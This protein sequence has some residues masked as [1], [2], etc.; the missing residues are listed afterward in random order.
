LL[1]TK[2]KKTEK[3][4]KEYKQ[5]A[6]D[7]SLQVQN[8]VKKQLQNASRKTY[9][10]NPVASLIQSSASSSND[11][12]RVISEN[13]VEFDDVDELQ[14]KNAN[15][16]QVVRRLT[17]ERETREKDPASSDELKEAL[18]QIAKLRERRQRQEVMVQSII[19]QRD[20]Y[21]LMSQQ[22]QQSGDNGNN[23]NNNVN[24]GNE[25]PLNNP[26]VST[27]VA[28]QS[29]VA[30]SSSPSSSSSSSIVEERQSNEILNEMKMEFEAIREEHKETITAL[31]DTLEAT[32]KSE[33]EMRVQHGR[34]QAEV[35]FLNDKYETLHKTTQGERDELTRMRSKNVSGQQMVVEHQRRLK[36]ME[37][38]LSAANSQLKTLNQKIHRVEAEKEMK[39]SALE[40]AEAD[41]HRLKGER[42]RQST[43]LEAMQKLERNLDSRAASNLERVQEKNTRLEKELEVSKKEI[44]AHTERIESLRAQIVRDETTYN[45]QVERLKGELKGCRED[46]ERMKTSMEEKVED[47]FILRNELDK[48]KEEVFERDATIKSLQTMGEDGSEPLIATASQV[49]RL[50]LEI[51]TARADYNSALATSAE[52]DKHIEEF[53]AIARANEEALSIQATKLNN[54]IANLTDELNTT[55]DNLESTNATL[56]ERQDSLT[57]NASELTNLQREMDSK[58]EEWK[59]KIVD[60]EGKV[61]EA[62]ENCE[63]AV[64]QQLI[65]D[66][67]AES[68]DSSRKVAEENYQREL[69]LHAEDSKRIQSVEEELRNV[70]K[71]RDSA[72]TKIAELTTEIVESSR[73]WSML[74]ASLEKMNEDNGERINDLTAQNDLLHAQLE[75]VTAKVQLMEDVDS[76]GSNVGDDGVTELSSGDSSSP[77]SSSSTAVAVQTSESQLRLLIQHLRKDKNMVEAQLELKRSSCIRLEHDVLQLR[78]KVDELRHQQM[79]SQ[80]TEAEGKQQDVEHA[81]LLEDV[82][83]MNLFRESNEYLQKNNQELADK[84]KRLETDVVDLKENLVPLQEEVRTLKADK[85]SLEAQGEALQKENKMWQNRVER[86][87]KKYHQIDPQEHQNLL[88]KVEGHTKKVEELTSEY[89]VSYIVKIVFTPFY[90]LLLLFI[91][92]IFLYAHFVVFVYFKHSFSSLL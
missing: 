87:V 20:M 51:T 36:M 23:I 48:S 44:E 74:R 66:K 5:S 68:C 41:V 65:S 75:N 39:S 11:A 6:A 92:L 12:S 62:V 81:K 64:K 71:A 2:L 37:N 10:S 17:A 52:K 73:S 57:A 49:Q 29:L 19:K 8:L 32:R 70:T 82:K 56:R 40:R 7:L 24:N 34:M 67:H 25:D 59:K 88:D 86:L 22:L 47:I 61:K 30:S 28:G 15:L 13:L 50:K 21:R 35:Q 14:R 3:E 72:E 60:M 42:E 4:A 45:G 84:N 1:S 69:L 26:S 63:S 76:I 54:E 43:V 33:T 80:A 16:L 53:K 55:K 83:K 38:E 31:R 85:M 46:I 91:R 79:Q 89:D 90:S 58:E 77:S 9:M 27:N 78:K 18:A